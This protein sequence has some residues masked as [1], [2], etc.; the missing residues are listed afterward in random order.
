MLASRFRVSKQRRFKGASKDAT[1]ARCGLL[2]TIDQDANN[3]LTEI[4]LL[5][6]NA[7]LSVGNVK[8]KK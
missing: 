5:H 1:K 8:G 6:Y 3:A 2:G 7:Y 4:I